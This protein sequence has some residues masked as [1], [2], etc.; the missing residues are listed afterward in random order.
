MRTTIR[1]SVRNSDIY[2]EAI[3]WPFLDVTLQESLKIPLVYVACF[4][5][6]KVVITCIQH[7]HTVYSRNLYLILAFHT[8]LSSFL[9]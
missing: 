3:E 8:P 6:D 9:H 2:I 7:M 5:P 4:S 1:P